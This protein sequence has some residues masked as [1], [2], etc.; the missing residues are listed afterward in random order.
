M[1]GKRTTSRQRD[2]RIPPAI[3]LAEVIRKARIIRSD[4]LATELRAT[5]VM[6]HAPDGNSI[7]VA[8]G[9]FA[10]FHA[11][12]WAET[13][14]ELVEVRLATGPS[15]NGTRNIPVVSKPSAVTFTSSPSSIE[16][17]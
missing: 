12:A 1:K 4:R 5:H 10:P 16:T 13:I 14:G 3:D 8:E 2:R 15:S 17:M 6:Q 9:S 7:P 11:H